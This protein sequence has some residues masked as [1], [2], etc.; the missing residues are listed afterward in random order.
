M[1]CSSTNQIQFWLFI[2]G[3]KGPLILVLK[4]FPETETVIAGEILSNRWIVVTLIVVKGERV[5]L[6][7]VFIY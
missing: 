7:L 4:D 5:L 6:I 3:N 2:S 1:Y